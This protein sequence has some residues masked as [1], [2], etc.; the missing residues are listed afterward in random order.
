M[1]LKNQDLTIHNLP[2]DNSYR[3]NIGPRPVLPART[4]LPAT[5]ISHTRQHSDTFFPIPCFHFKKIVLN[6]FHYE[7]I[8]YVPY[9][10]NNSPSPGCEVE[11]MRPGIQD[12]C[13]M[14][15]TSSQYRSPGKHPGFFIYP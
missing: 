9:R 11:F 6:L 4:F 12:V 7:N 3:I 10:R 1:N 5:P 13:E 14:K 15:I 8:I 2:F